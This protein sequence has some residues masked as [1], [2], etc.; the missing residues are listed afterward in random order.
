MRKDT[1]T[2]PKLIHS[3]LSY[4][5]RYH[6]LTKEMMVQLLNIKAQDTK[7]LVLLQSYADELRNREVGDAVSYRGLLEFSNVC[8]LDC[9]YCGIRRSN[10]NVERYTLDRETLVAQ[11]LWCARQGYGSVMLQS[12]QRNDRQFIDELIE[13][14]QE[15]K[16]T[17]RSEHLPDGLGIT[18]GI[19]EQSYETYEKLYTAGAHRYLLRIETTNRKVYERIH[20]EEQTY[21]N[22][23]SCLSYLKDIGYQVGTGV[24]IGIPGQSL[25]MLADDIQFFKEMDIDMI[26]MGPYIS[27]PDSPMAE[28]GMMENQQLLQL[29]LNMIAVTRIYLQDVNIAAATAL[30]AVTPDGREQGLRYGAN[31][32]MPNATPREVREGYQLYAGKPCLNEASSECSSCLSHRIHSVGRKVNLNSWGDSPHAIRKGL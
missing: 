6:S 21:E 18:L 31:V 15:I 26:G 7:A 11:A 28:Q 30:Q 16:H 27:H 29:A 5:R 10:T 32:V 24:M 19:G 1:H 9:H 20:P 2:D 17:S 4:H 14:I 13:I 25:G 3:I 8:V 23:L 22:R 12:G